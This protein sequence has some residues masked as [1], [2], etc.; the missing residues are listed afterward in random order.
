MRPSLPIAAPETYKIKHR[1]A[2]SDSTGCHISCDQ[3]RLQ[4]KEKYAFS[5]APAHLLSPTK[6]GNWRI[7]ATWS[8]NRR[9]WAQLFFWNRIIDLGPPGGSS[10]KQLALPAW[11][12]YRSMLDLGQNAAP[13]KGPEKIVR[14]VKVAESMSQRDTSLDVYAQN[15][16]NWWSQTSQTL[17]SLCMTTLC[18]SILPD[19]G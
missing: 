16:L 2:D 4:C 7:V 19:W 3:T 12:L 17:C 1:T 15:C 14:S 6:R 9:N 11:E 8:N 18:S 13:H 5:G 10:P